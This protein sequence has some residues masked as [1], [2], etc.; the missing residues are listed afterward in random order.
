MIHCITGFVGATEKT[1]PHRPKLSK[2]RADR[3]FILKANKENLHLG[4]LRGSF[5]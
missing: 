1:R 5:G 3:Y 2:L 4:Y